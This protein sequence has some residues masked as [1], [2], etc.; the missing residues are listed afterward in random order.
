[1]RELAQAE[2]GQVSGGVSENSG[3]TTTNS[4]RGN[5]D[6]TVPGGGGGLVTTTRN[7][8]GNAPPGQQDEE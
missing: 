8:G 4:P 1:M 6:K 7:R 5:P 3:F 2:L